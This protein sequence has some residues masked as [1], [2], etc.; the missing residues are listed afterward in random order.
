MEDPCRNTFEPISLV[1][2]KM[3]CFYCG[4][5]NTGSKTVDR[6]YGIKHCRIHEIVAVRDCN[7][8]LQRQGH[9]RID[10]AFKNAAISRFMMVIKD[11]PTFPVERSD[12]SI[13]NNWSL[14]T[15]SWE[16]R[17]YIS[18]NV[19]GKW[20]IPV[21]KN[22]ENLYK[23]VPIINFLKPEIAGKMLLPAAWHQ[24]IEDT[25]ETLIDGVYK[26]DQEAYEKALNLDSSPLHE[27]DG[28]HVT[29]FEGR[30]V[31]IM[32]PKIDEAPSE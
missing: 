14:E 3:E 16:S 21:K 26:A 11:N 28:V 25:L 15:D 23:Y 9:V 1:M 18:K 24:V 19:D 5:E 7:A 22:T 27:I 10:D 8:Y 32:L 6:L 4:A 20:S 31:R 17:A 12:G 30:A 2:R 29:E 13:E